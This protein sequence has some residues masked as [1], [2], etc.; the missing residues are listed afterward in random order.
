VSWQ[1]LGDAP[2][3]LIALRD[4]GTRADEQLRAALRAA[5]KQGVKGLVLDLR[6]NPGGLE[7]QAVA[8]TSEFITEGNVFLEQNA[9]GRR[10]AVPI[11]P[12]GVAGDLPLVVLIDQG[13]AS[14]AEIFAGAVQDHGRGKL[15]GTRTFGTGTVLKTYEL[16]D[17][18]VVMLAVLEWL[19][20]DGRRIWH[21]GID[22]DVT[23]ALPDRA[24]VLNPDQAEPLSRADIDKSEDRQLI[25][26]L[27]VLDRQFASE[28]AGNR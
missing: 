4:F 2:V 5:R 6:G 25:E 27:K 15:V 8:V 19:T 9:Q 13:T 24:S 10:K 3:A 12:D 7:K 26:A 17:G 23:V 18:S 21:H 20:P 16:S 14:S 22:P 11:A 1:V 28:K